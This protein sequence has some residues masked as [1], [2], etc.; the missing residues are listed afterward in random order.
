MAR[1]DRSGRAS[2]GGAPGRTLRPP[3]SWEAAAAAGPGK[4]LPA[5][6][7]RG[8]QRPALASATLSLGPQEA[9]VARVCLS[10]PGDRAMGLGAFSE[11]IDCVSGNF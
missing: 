9:Q 7:A 10:M 2:E 8:G 1:V 6:E 11:F 3:E 4:M 5:P